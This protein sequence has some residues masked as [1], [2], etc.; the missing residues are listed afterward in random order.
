MKTTIA[1]A[2]CVL[3]TLAPPA[4][5]LEYQIV[6]GGRNRIVFVS[7][8]PMEMFQGHTDRVSGVIGLDR[9]HPG[10]SV[11]VRVVVDMAGLT[12]G[13]TKRD[14]HM[15]ENHLETA[16]FP[17]ATFE[18]ATVRAPAN[19]RLESGRPAQFD[20]E[21]TFTLHGVSRR[22]RTTIDASYAEEKGVPQIRFRTS[23]KVVLGDYGI[24]RPE[25]LFLKLA[26]TQDVKVDC[27]AVLAPVKSL[28]AVGQP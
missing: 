17:T 10:D 3:S 12:T 13:I 18:G 14:E 4:R 25:F 9:D 5:A 8:A 2:L 1:I 11:S 15:R 26:E 20:L 19:A 28:G 21:G 22:L 16:R 6:P 24:T 7:K 23:F 27:T